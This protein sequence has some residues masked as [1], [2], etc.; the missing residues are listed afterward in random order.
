MEVLDVIYTP[1]Q[2]DN[3]NYLFTVSCTIADKTSPEFNTKY[4][5]TEQLVVANFKVLRVV[6]HQECL[7]RLLEVAGTFQNELAA[8]MMMNK[9]PQDRVSY[10]GGGDGIRRKL[11]VIL[12]DT[13]QIMASEEMKRHKKSSR[14]RVV[15]SVKVRIIANLDELG[16]ILTSR[17]RPLAEMNVKKFVAN[18]VLKTSYTEVNMGLKDIQVIDLNPN[19]I[20]KNV[21][22]NI[23]HR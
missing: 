4:N 12:E 3:S 2:D 1:D 13:E 18:I 6:L 16:L 7:K 17:S 9:P 15:E 21:R 22:V 19:T 11:T 8:I 23:F 5:S 14:N 20:H 10:A